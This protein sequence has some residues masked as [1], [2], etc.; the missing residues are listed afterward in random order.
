MMCECCISEIINGIMYKN[1]IGEFIC[2]EC[3]DNLKEVEIK[4]GEVVK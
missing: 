3:K 1:D 4:N 2:K